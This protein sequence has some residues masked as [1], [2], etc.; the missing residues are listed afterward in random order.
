M[1]GAICERV[2]VFRTSPSMYFWFLTAIFCY[3]DVPKNR[4]GGTRFLPLL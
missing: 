1:S 2:R 3:H 4:G